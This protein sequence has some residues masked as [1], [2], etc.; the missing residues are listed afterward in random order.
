M[1]FTRRSLIARA[2]Q[3]SGAAVV[4][5]AV[6]AALAGP[7]ERPSALAPWRPLRLPAPPLRAVDYLVVADEAGR[8]LD[9]TW[10]AEERAYS[11][12]GGGIDATYSAALLTIH[13]IAAERG[14]DG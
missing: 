12:G 2:A 5:S 3:A 10:V 11:A 7:H 9:R 1:P 8:R 6:P 14:H 13:A 4:A